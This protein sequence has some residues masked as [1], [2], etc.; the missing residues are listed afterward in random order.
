MIFAVGW[1]IFSTIKYKSQYF[2]GLHGIPNES[3]R[4]HRNKKSAGYNRAF[5]STLLLILL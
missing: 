3:S 4:V 5:L 1:L 2:K